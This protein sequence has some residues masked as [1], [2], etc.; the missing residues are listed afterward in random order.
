MREPYSKV[1]VWEDK[2]SIP[3]YRRGPED[4]NPPLLISRR[5][6]IHPGS[7]IIYPYPMQDNLTDICEDQF[8]KVLFLENDFLL[9]TVLPELGGHVL[10]VLDKVTGEEAM[11][12]NHVLKFNRIGIRGAWVSGGIEWN[13]PNGHTVTTTSSIDYTIRNN[14]DG[15]ATIYISDVEM[16]SRMK[17]SVGIT[18]YPQYAYFETKIR[19]FNRTFLPNR[20]WFW[21]NSAVPISEG[22]EF[23]TTATKVMTLTDVMNFPVHDGVDISWDKNHLEAQDLFSLNPRDDFVAW[24]NHDLQ[25]G[26]VNHADRY[27][28][29]GKKF[30]TW[31]NSDDGNIWTELLTDKDGPYAEMQSG[32]LRTMRIWEILHPYTVESWKEI[33]YPIRKIGSPVY[34]NSE[35]CLACKPKPKEKLI[36]L[37]VQTTSSRPG[38]EISLR[39]DEK[40]VWSKKINLDP[41]NPFST[42]ITVKKEHLQGKETLLTL[43]DGDGEILAEVRKYREKEPEEEIR[44]YY[45]IEPISDAGK[46]EEFWYNGISYE[47]LGEPERAMESYRDALKDDTDFIQAQVFLGVLHVRSGLHEEAIA[48]LNEALKRDKNCHEARFFLGVCHMMREQFDDAIDELLTLFRSKTYG[49]ASSYLLGGVYLGKGE[50]KRAIRQ[51]EKSLDIYPQNFDVKAHLACAWRKIGNLERANSFIQ[52]IL[53]EDPTNYLAL[54]EAYFTAQEQEDREKRAD[55][56]EQL[57]TVL[58]DEEQSY[59]ELASAYIFFSLYN[60]GIH[61]LRLCIEQKGHT[62]QNPLLHY[63]LGYYLEKIGRHPEAKKYVR[64]GGEMEPSFVF[65]HRIESERI[66][67]WVIKTSP[68]DGKAKYYLGNLLCAKGRGLEAIKLWQEAAKNLKGFSVLHRN[69]GRASWRILKDPDRAVK[70]YEKALKLAPEDY[71]LYYEADKLYAKCGLIEKRKTLIENVPESLKRNDI[72]AERCA[73]FYTDTYNFDRVLDILRSTKFFPWE[74]YTE[75]RRLYEAANMGKGLKLM[76]M[77]NFNEAINSFKEVMKYPRNIG[78]GEPA[79]KSHAEALYRIGLANERQ[80]NKKEAEKYYKLARGEEHKGWNELRYYEAKAHGRL[81]ESTK[82]K[83]IFD[84][85]IAHANKK[86]DQEEGDKAHNLYLA[87]LGHKGRGNLLKAKQ[88]FSQALMEDCTHRRSRWEVDGLVED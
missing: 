45:K 39:I 74:F 3:T 42:E 7:C 57:R 79:K 48:A 26:M 43:R 54:A 56:K 35:A 22:L 71:R 46:A 78:V 63:Y 33:W 40:K 32:R 34:A 4:Q 76:S 62:T 65:P 52:A 50:I 12:R 2:I 6:P 61:I 44:E 10:S 28:A 15:S 21:A 14:Q 27:E 37:G 19:L 16:V 24:Y 49:A 8:W 81:N 38:S 23:I 55:R 69:L 86:L 64:S 77:G 75:G 58:R 67:R 51:L 29:C 87:G 88:Y 5:N 53:K 70:E 60:E 13:F 31:G 72:V 20:F 18:L 82:G 17:W 1:K 36:H 83:R 41:S 9:I 25:R 30:Y 80:G 85:L 11:Y 66:L 47:K 73:S 68:E 59:L 84:D